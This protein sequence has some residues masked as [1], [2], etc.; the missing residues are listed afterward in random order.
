MRPYLRVLVVA[1][2]GGVALYALSAVLGVPFGV[3]LWI[4]MA[5]GVT[6]LVSN[7]IGRKS[8]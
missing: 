7:E 5:G 1:A 6:A 8:D 3:A 4:W 2:I